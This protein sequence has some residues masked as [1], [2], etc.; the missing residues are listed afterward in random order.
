LHNEW[1]ELF[2]IEDAR[3]RRSELDTYLDRCRGSCALRRPDLA[4]LVEGAI[5]FYHLKHY[6][7]RAWVVMPN[8][9]QVLFKVG[10]S[11]PLSKIMR[12]LKEFTAR[13]INKRLHR[14]GQ[15]W[16][17]DYWDTYMRDADHEFR[18]RC[19]IENN[20]V[21]AFLVRER[22]EWPWSSARFRDDYETLHLP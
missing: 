17:E 9:V 13:E 3:E 16:M 8:H 1:V 22:K 4:E 20:P 6:Q 10:S 11:T 15:F 2:Q 19:Y 14:W 12:N 5:R 7:L 21:K 18:A